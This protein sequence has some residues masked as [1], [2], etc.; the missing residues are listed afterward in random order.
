M[1][2]RHVLTHAPVFPRLLIRDPFDMS[3]HVTCDKKHE[4][5]GR[6]KTTRGPPRGA[7]GQPVEQQDY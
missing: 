4:D 3:S 6:G 7:E 2:D 5:P 1:T